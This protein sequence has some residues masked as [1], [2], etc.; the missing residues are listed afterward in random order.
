M[1]FCYSTL[2]T[3]NAALSTFVEER[4]MVYVLY[5]RNFV[6]TKQNRVKGSRQATV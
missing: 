5:L 2:K 3:N 4:N 1:Y 6:S